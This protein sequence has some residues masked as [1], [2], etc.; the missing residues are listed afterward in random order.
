[1]PG[2]DWTGTLV[3]DLL[4]LLFTSVAI[5]FIKNVPIHLPYH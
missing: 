1:M 5:S 3:T 4:R 2:N